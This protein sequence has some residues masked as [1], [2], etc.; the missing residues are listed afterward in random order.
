[1]GAVSLL[2]EVQVFHSWMYIKMMGA[3]GLRLATE[4]AILNANYASKRLEDLI[5]LYMRG[6]MI[7]LLMNVS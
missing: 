3:E 7:L 6:K 4:V 1:M 2:R 5:K